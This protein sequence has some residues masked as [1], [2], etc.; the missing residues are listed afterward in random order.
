L[1]ILQR[2]DIARGNRH[3]RPGTRRRPCGTDPGDVDLGRHDQVEVHDLTPTE[4]R[5]VCRHELGGPLARCRFSTHRQYRTGERAEIGRSLRPMPGHERRPDASGGQSE[6]HEHEPDTQHPD[7]RRSLI[8]PV[9]RRLDANDAS[10]AASR[11]AASTRGTAERGAARRDG[12]PLVLDHGCSGSTAAIDVASTVNVAPSIPTGA[13]TVARACS[14]ATATDTDAPFGAV[15]LAAASPL[16]PR[17]ALSAPSRAA[18][19]HWS[20][21]VTAFTA[22]TPT[23]SS[24][25]SAGNATA[26]S[27]VVEPRSQRRGG[28]PPH[29]RGFGG[30]R[31]SPGRASTRPESTAATQALDRPSGSVGAGSTSA[32]SCLDAAPPVTRAP[33]GSRR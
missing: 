5:A 29:G 9:L 24:T 27:A 19:T 28:R 3:D 10:R 15:R 21:T 17:A 13:D 8:G 12:R 2:P 16:S 32:P 14:P 11:T 18:D 31:Q 4:P 20:L 26:S 33:V 30:R 22:S 6:Q 7:R 23:I 25:I 1:I